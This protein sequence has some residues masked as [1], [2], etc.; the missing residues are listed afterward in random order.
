[1]SFTL[2][3][4]NKSIIQNGKETKFTSKE[5]GILS[6]LVD[7]PDTI[8]SA[9]EI[10]QNVWDEIPFNCKGLM[11][12]HIRHIREKIEDNPSTPVY[13]DSFW[14]RGYRFNTLS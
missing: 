13:L 3:K 5:F 1:M 2:N 14:K 9:E 12:V 10:Y 8:H 7:H 4:Q 6:Y 11:C